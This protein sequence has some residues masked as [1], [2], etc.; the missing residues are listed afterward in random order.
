MW[1]EF[2]AKY[3]LQSNK[4]ISNN[5][6]N[7]C[8][9]RERE[10][11][12]WWEPWE[13]RCVIPD[14]CSAWDHEAVKYLHH[15]F[16]LLLWLLSLV[17]E[18]WEVSSMWGRWPCVWFKHVCVWFKVTLCLVQA[19]VCVVQGDPVCRSKEVPC[20]I[21][22]SVYTCVLFRLEGRGGGSIDLTSVNLF[23]VVKRPPNQPK[24]QLVLLQ[25]CLLLVSNFTTPWSVIHLVLRLGICCKAHQESRWYLEPDELGMW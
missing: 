2:R 24:L 21:W 1:I 5:G 14:A 8:V 25:L 17:F 23:F 10:E 3:W 13:W 18:R 7:G 9:G 22:I 6:G 11:G 16:S 12:G 15:S 4:T 20:C 19:C